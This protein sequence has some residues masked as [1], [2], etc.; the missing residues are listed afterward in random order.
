[1]MVTL[2]Y[3][4]FLPCHGNGNLGKGWYSSYWG[5]PPQSCGT[6]LAIWD[7]SV[8]CYPTQV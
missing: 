8:N 3:Q 7:R 2:P 4:M 1:M 5:S 6:S